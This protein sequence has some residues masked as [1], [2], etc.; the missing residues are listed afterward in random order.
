MMMRDILQS[1]FTHFLNGLFWE[2]HM[3]INVIVILVEALN[4]GEKKTLV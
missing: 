4:I 1:E 2:V 3:L